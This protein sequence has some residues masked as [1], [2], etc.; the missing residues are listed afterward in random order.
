MT[1]QKPDALT[2]SPEAQ[3]HIDRGVSYLKEC[4]SI[5]GDR[6]ISEAGADD[7]INNGFAAFREAIQ[8]DPKARSTVAEAVRDAWRWLYEEIASRVDVGDEYDEYSDANL[9]WIWLKL[10]QTAMELAPDHIGLRLDYVDLLRTGDWLISVKTGDLEIEA[11]YREV[12]RLN[13]THFDT[14][15]SHNACVF[16]SIPTDRVI[17]ENPLAYAIRDKFPVT[18]GHLLVIPKRHA[19]NYFSLTQDELLACDGLLRR[20]RDDFRDNDSSVEG[21]N[22]GMNA[23]EVAGQTVFH[24]HIHLIPR[25]RGDVPDPRGG[26]RNLIPGKGL[27]SND[28][29]MK[30]EQAGRGRGPS[31]VDSSA[32]EVSVERFFRAPLT[33]EDHWRAIIL[34]GANVANYK[35]ALAA[36]LLELQ[37]KSGQVLKFSDLAE[38]FSRHVSEALKREDKQCTSPTNSYLDACRKFNRKEISKDELIGTTVKKAFGD[39]V[40]RFHNVRGGKT[41]SFYSPTSGGIQITDNFSTLLQS[42]HI[43]SLPVEVDQRW[44]VVEHAWQLGVSSHALSGDITCNFE[45]EKKTFYGETFKNGKK[46]R[47]S[48]AGILGLL[49]GY[50]MGRCFYCFRTMSLASEGLRPEVDHFFPF[51]LMSYRFPPELV[52]GA[53]NLVL[54]C[55][56]C[57]RGVGGKFDLLPDLSLLER[58]YKRNKHLIS[59]HNPLQE[60]IKRQAGK[61]S[62]RQH[63]IIQ[64]W[65]SEA[66]P[67]LI[68]SWSGP[69]EVFGLNP[70]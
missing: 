31:I 64:K 17:A 49:N 50:Q 12:L 8:C 42:P 60:V 41:L 29:S 55:E 2:P 6:V 11:A 13:P 38:P 14:R 32:N 45:K 19:E 27:P 67:H 16:C 70:F 68:H 23:G 52:N 34:R 62:A 46:Q 59:S 15:F 37:P 54:S 28:Q 61:T 48:L 35:F 9:N 40:P 22:I 10:Y 56:A 18:D 1:T 7:L 58:L 57:N 33:L 26:V 24:C 36:T 44:R 63:K 53:W 66:S 20:L 3:A 47:V 25:R 39:V 4:A 43:H 65:H 30:R 5:V 69:P 21:F 51:V